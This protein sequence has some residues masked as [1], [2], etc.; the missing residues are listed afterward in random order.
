MLKFRDRFILSVFLCK[1]IHVQPIVCN[2]GA[3]SLGELNPRGVRSSVAS[4]ETVVC[5]GGLLE[6]Q[7]GLCRI[8][9]NRI[10]SPA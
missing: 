3:D 6:T 8:V 7:I 5:I 1:K 10:Q 9:S 4:N 2:D